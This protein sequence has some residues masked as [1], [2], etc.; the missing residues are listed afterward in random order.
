M[1]GPISFL[2]ALAVALGNAHD[3]RTHATE[4]SLTGAGKVS[5]GGGG[6][7]LQAST[8]LARASGLTG[9]ETSAYT[10]MIC[11]MVADG[12]WPLFDALYIFATNNTTTANLNLIST[13]FGLTK[14]GTVTFTADV[15]YTGDGTTGFFDTAYAPSTTAG[16]LTLNSAS[17]GVYIQSTSGT[18]GR[19]VMGVNNNGPS[20][21][22]YMVPTSSGSFTWDVNGATFPSFTNS[23]SLGIWTASRLS[24]SVTNVYQNGNLTP[25]GISVSDTSVNLPAFHFY[26]LALDS[27][28]AANLFSNYQI[29]A[30]YIG[31]GLIAAHAVAVNNRIN[32]YMTALG[33]NVY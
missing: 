23:N 17:I 7:C 1:R 20:S 25:V 4:M 19:V 14:A 32:A 18:S 12:T 24:S 5:G 10:T 3:W 16:N 8:F 33:H 26:I 29:S 28:G 2:I 15:G 11:G 21:F 13:S 6:G 30:A 22:L 27:V 9:T 31:G